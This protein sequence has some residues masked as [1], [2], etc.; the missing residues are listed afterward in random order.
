MVSLNTHNPL[1]YKEWKSYYEDSFNASELPIL[2][3]NYLTEWKTE[4]LEKN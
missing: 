4:K 3:N 1:S 2:Y